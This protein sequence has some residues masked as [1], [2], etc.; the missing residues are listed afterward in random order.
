R[1][2]RNLLFSGAKLSL[3]IGAAVFAIPKDWQLSAIIASWVAG[4]ALASLG[5]AAVFRLKGAHI[6]YRPSFD[7]LRRLS[8][9]AF[10]HYLLNLAATV[11]SLLLPVIIALVLSPE[12]NAPFYAAWMMLS[13]A[14]IAPSAL[15]TVLFS[16]GSSGSSGA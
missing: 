14:G 12:Q 1:L 2:L 7:L 5:L 3:V 6:W 9:V 11:P 4:Q 16:V 15:A 10:W 8:G 13:L